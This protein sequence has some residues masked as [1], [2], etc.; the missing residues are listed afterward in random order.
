MARE[1]VAM[2]RGD[3]RMS[4]REMGME[5]ELEEKLQKTE[6]RLFLSLRSEGLVCDAVF[7][8]QFE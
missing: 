1:M 4:E 7:R 8:V 3:R 5:L 6:Q 2:W